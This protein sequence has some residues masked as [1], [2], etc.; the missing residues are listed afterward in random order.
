MQEH[1]NNRK[2]LQTILTMPH[3]R[4]DRWRDKWRH[5]VEVL[6]FF[7]LRP[8]MTVCEIWPTGGWYSRILA[9]YLAGNGQLY[10]AH[11]D[12][13]HTDEL[14]IMQRAEFMANMNSDPSL[15]RTT[16]VTVFG[17]GL[18]PP[19]PPQSCDLILCVLHI[20]N[21]LMGGYASEALDTM[22]V[23]LKTSGKIGIVQH[24][25]AIAELGP[26]DGSKGYLTQEFVIDLM[27]ANG[28]RFL[29]ESSIA[30]NPLDKT[31]HE[32]GAWAL[33]P[34]MRGAKSVQ[35]KA[36]RLE[37][38]ASNRMIMTFELSL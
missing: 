16:E 7:G 14:L 28:F 5:P 20:H 29:D 26:T 22:R 11:F 2:R 6:E 17:R 9:P 12:P 18:N 27:E 33:P 35:E 19:C 23:G 31:D 8:D 10:A 38:G 34:S 25:A 21:F 15:Y 1:P 32:E 4:D 24:R 3:R 13:D 30:A 37:I 36:K